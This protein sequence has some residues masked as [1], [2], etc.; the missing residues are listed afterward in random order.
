VILSANQRITLVL[1][2]D[3][4]KR[5]WLLVPASILILGV[6]AYFL[7]DAP[8]ARQPLEGKLLR[9]TMDQAS[10]EWAEP[11][12]I[13]IVELPDGQVVGAT[14]SSLWSPPPAGSLVLIEEQVMLFGRLRYRIR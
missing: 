11:N 9:W 7:L 2:W 1:A 8:I 3:W 13:A 14:A 4:I 10:I 6:A 12:A 5:N